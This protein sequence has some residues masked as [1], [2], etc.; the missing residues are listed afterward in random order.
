MATGSRITPN[1][2]GRTFGQDNGVSTNEGRGNRQGFSNSNEIAA[3]IREQRPIQAIDNDVAG[4]AEAA[5]VMMNDTGRLRG[6]PMRSKMERGAH[7]TLRNVTR[8]GYAAMAFDF[9]QGIGNIIEKL[10]PGIGQKVVDKTVGP[11]IDSLIKAGHSKAELSEYSKDKLTKLVNKELKGMS[12]N[13]EESKGSDK[14]E[15]KGSDERVN[16][17]DYPVYEPDTKSASTFRK[18]FA[19]A[20]E[21]GKDTFSFEGRDYNTKEKLAKG[22]VVKKAHN[23]NRTSQSMQYN[24]IDMG[25]FMKKVK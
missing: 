17:K 20:K 14:E 25:K 23:G 8:A 7:A 5:D 10:N 22:G 18:E 6:G 16:K 21:K 15:G 1:R 12:F 4:L 9:G 3:D 19:S 24:S 2:T 11:V 13:K